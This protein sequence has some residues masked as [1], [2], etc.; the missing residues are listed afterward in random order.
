MKNDCG[1]WKNE[2]LEAA[3]TGTMAPELEQH[4]ASCGECVKTMEVLRERRERLDALLPRVARGAEPP[5]GLGAK[6]L[7]AAQVAERQDHVTRRWTW[8]LVAATAT[9]AAVVTAA[10]VARRFPPRA[11]AD[12]E[13]AAAERLARWQAPSDTLLETPGY[14]ILRSTPK[15]GETY[16]QTPVRTNEEE[17]K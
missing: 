12:P 17:Q 11:N 16:L 9:I 14:E 1:R 5:A 3:L 13:I 6:V 4:L 10:L 8:R 2:L 7:A 15:L